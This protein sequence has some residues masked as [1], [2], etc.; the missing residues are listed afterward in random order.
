MGPNAMARRMHISRPFSHFEKVSEEGG[1]EN[2]EHDFDTFG[3]G[4]DAGDRGH[5]GF[6]ASD[7]ESARPV[8]FRDQRTPDDPGGQL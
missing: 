6:G 2:E 5:H 1:N 3:A 8:L 4:G 7:F